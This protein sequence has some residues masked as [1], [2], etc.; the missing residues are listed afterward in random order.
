MIGSGHKSPIQG[1]HKSDD[2]CK[3]KVSTPTACRGSEVWNQTAVPA[4]H[5]NM[6]F[7]FVV[8]EQNVF[9]D[10]SRQCRP[11]SVHSV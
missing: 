2:A 9:T 1:N 8:A 5:F 11:H 7:I 3:L 4:D 6:F 10:G